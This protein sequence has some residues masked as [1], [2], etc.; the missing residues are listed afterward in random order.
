MSRFLIPL[1]CFLLLACPA[2][3]GEESGGK[4]KLPLPSESHVA[5][6]R[7]VFDLSK[8]PRPYVVFLVLDQE[9][10]LYPSFWCGRNLSGKVEFHASLDLLDETL[11]F[12]HKGSFSVQLTNA[13]HK[14]GMADVLPGGVWAEGLRER[15]FCITIDEFSDAVFTG[16][17]RGKFAK[18]KGL[19]SSG[20]IVFFDV[21]IRGSVKADEKT[22]PFTGKAALG[23]VDIPR[24]FTLHAKFPFP[25]KE[26][27]L[28]GQ[29]GEGITASLYTGSATTMNPD[30]PT[31]PAADL[32][33]L[34]N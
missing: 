8:N 10:N 17:R 6:A 13:P 34:F 3:A 9:E 15:N 2:A 14:K 11:H 31:I 26:L 16:A 32:D 33:P 20:T 12:R 19:S 29:K 28:A 24:V 18:G 1:L 23:F 27:G 7:G 25:G 5:N 30:M 21:T 22:A 4:K